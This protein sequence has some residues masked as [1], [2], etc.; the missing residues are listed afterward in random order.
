MA[1]RG[2]AF[3][4]IAGIAGID[5]SSAA[6]GINEYFLMV[7]FFDR[8]NLPQFLRHACKEIVKPSKKSRPGVSYG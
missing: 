8:A 6:N 3:P 1:F 2:S 7:C 4:A 5:A